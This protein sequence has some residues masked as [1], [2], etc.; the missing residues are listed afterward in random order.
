MGTKRQPAYPLH[1]SPFYKLRS[2][3][4]LAQLLEID[5]GELKL[6]VTNCDALYK[7]FDIQKKSGGTRRVENPARPLKLIQA[8][9]ARF[10][11]RIRPPDYLFCPV[12]GRSYVSNAAQHRNGRVI[13]CLDIRKYFPNTPSRRV[14]WFFQKV[15]QCEPDVAAVLAKLATYRQH[16]ATGSPLSPIMAYFAYFDVWEGVAQIA[17]QANCVLTV[18]ID[19]VTIS[20]QIVRA[21]VLWDV[22]RAIHRAGLRYHKAKTYIDQPAEVTGVI[23]RDGTLCPPNRQKRKLMLTKR[24]LAQKPPESLEKK[25]TGQLKGLEGQ[26]SQIIQANDHA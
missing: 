12:K 18:Y 23:I 22:K 24:A 26:L 10:L 2:R 21:S 17:R 11:G 15:M 6:L 25:L 13:R 4:K 8:R 5:H 3:R 16:L 14:Y 7:E 19:D 20:G 1:Q 9:V